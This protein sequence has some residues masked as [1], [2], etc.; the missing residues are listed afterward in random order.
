M[1][2]VFVDA[3]GVYYGVLTIFLYR[4]YARR[5]S[6]FASNAGRACMC[7][8]E[9]VMLGVGEFIESSI[10]LFNYFSMH[11]IAKAWWISRLFVSRRA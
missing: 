6:S 5:P 9:C 7:V 3:V 8:C 4:F 11:G 10:V 2:F 1:H